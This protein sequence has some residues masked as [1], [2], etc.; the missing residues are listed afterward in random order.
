MK[1]VLK[2][3]CVV[4]IL[5]IVTDSVRLLCFNSCSDD[6][7]T[8]K[9]WWE[10]R[11]KVSFWI[12]GEFTI[13]TLDASFRYP[14]DFTYHIQNFSA[15]SYQKIVKPGQEASVFYSFIPAD[16]FAGRPI[17]LTI[18]LAYRYYI[19]TGESVCVKNKVLET[20]SKAIRPEK[21]RVKPN[22]HN[23]FS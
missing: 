8:W 10:W 22:I 23:P 1:F 18:N 19:D 21:L 20:L 3:K 4:M 14:M 6:I 17:G 13:E 16:A 15:I 11:M 5:L 9:V 2:L 12:S 7:C